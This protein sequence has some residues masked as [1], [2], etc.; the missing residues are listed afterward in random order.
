[1]EYSQVNKLNEFNGPIK[2][3]PNERNVSIEH[4]D[5]CKSDLSITPYII[6]DCGLR[7]CI[8]CLVKVTL[9]FSQCPKCYYIFTLD[10][11]DL[12]FSVQFQE[13]AIG[14][15]IEHYFNKTIETDKRL[16]GQTKDYNQTA[17]DYVEHLFRK[18]YVKIQSLNCPSIDTLISYIRECYNHYDEGKRL[19]K[20]N[21]AERLY[22]LDDYINSRISMNEFRQYI[23]NSI[24]VYW[25]ILYMLDIIFEIISC[26]HYYLYASST[27]LIRKYKTL[28]LTNINYLIK[29]Y[30]EIVNKIYSYSDM[31]DCLNNHFQIGFPYYQGVY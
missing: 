10:Q 27:S 25:N 19:L 17:N 9:D 20:T 11:L 4:C 18:F 31:I 23:S 14:A 16:I 13:L 7:Y 8:D 6:C 29:D 1:M 26:V 12:E 15:R 21:I 30:T 24:G 22:K 28:G 2:V 3:E 5:N